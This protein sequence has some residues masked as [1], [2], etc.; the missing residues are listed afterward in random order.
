ME[1]PRGVQQGGRGPSGAR[2]TPWLWDSGGSQRGFK[3]PQGTQGAET[4]SDTNKTNKCVNKAMCMIC[5]DSPE[6]PEGPKFLTAINTEGPEGLKFSTAI[7]TEGP[8][9]LKFS[10]ATEG[11]KFSTSMRFSISPCLEVQYYQ[12]GPRGRGSQRPRGSTVEDQKTHAL[13]HRIPSTTLRPRG[14]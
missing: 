11:L 9:G 8:E 4:A 6:G 13:M 5:E 1:V 3:V 10:I 14:S 12:K 7:N 2:S